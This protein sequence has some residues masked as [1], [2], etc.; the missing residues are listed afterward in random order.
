M[1]DNKLNMISITNNKGKNNK[2][3]LDFLNM[4]SKNKYIFKYSG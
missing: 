1:L 4:I 2:L 3:Y